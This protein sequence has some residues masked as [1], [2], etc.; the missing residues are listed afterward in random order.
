[1]P[2]KKRDLILLLVIVVVLIVVLPVL[3]RAL[4]GG[5]YYMY[6]MGG[7]MGGYWFMPLIPVTFLVLLVLGAYFLIQAFGDAD[8]AAKPDQSKGALELL[9]ERYARGEL[10]REEYLQMTEELES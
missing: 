2:D 9:R 3:L 8:R 5:S 10:T 6:G 1:M 7:M 4:W